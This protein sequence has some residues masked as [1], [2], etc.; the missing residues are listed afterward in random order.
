MGAGNGLRIGIPRRGPALFAYAVLAAL[1]LMALAVSASAVRAW[2]ATPQPDPASDSPH[3][4]KAP[5]DPQTVRAVG[6]PVPRIQCQAGYTARILAEGLSSPDG[7]A[8]SPARVLYVAE[9]TAGRVSRVES[10]GSVAPILGGLRNPEGIAFDDTG[11]LYVVEDVNAGRVVKMTAAGVTTTLAAGR[12]AP[13]GAVWSSDGLLY[14]T[15]SNVQ[16]ASSPFAFRT[17]VT[18]VSPGAG[19]TRI[20]TNTLPWSYAGIAIGPAG[21]LYV[22]NEASG[23][24]TDDSIFS[25]EPV[26]GKRELFASGLVAPE[27]S[28]FSTGGGFPLYVAEEN[29]GNAGGRLSRVEADGSHAPF[30]TGFSSIEDVVV[31]DAGRLFVSEDGTGSIIR[32]ELDP[33]DRA[34]A[35]AI[36]LFVGDGMGEAH[37]TAGRWSAAG[38]TGVLAMD[39]MPFGGW[40]RTASA[41]NSVTDSAAGATAIATGIKTD[42]GVI[43]QDPEGNPLTTILERAKAAGMAVGL[44]TTTQMAHATPAAFAAHVAQRSMMDEIARQMLAA[45]VDVLLGGGE[46]VFLPDTVVGCYPGLGA[47]TDGRNLID[48]AE[49]DGYTYVC[50]APTLAGVDPGPTTRLLG[51]FADEGLS[52]PFSPSLVEMTQKAID[53]LSNDPDGFFLMVEGGQIDWAAHSNDAANVISDT[54]GLDGA[55]AVAQA[56]ASTAGDVLIIVTADHETG[57]MRADLASSGA[58]DEDGPFFMPGGTPFYVNWT[59]GGHTA[60][61]VPIT[62]QGPWSDLLIGVFE[63]T[64]THDVMRLALGGQRVFM[65]IVVRVGSSPALAPGPQ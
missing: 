47:R 40:S 61:H 35:R 44:V 46:N 54:V 33:P 12:D 48:E 26:T 11:N 22:T 58:P 64:H 57:G 7:L 16:F 38:Q 55:V 42:N 43:G 4:P 28:S 29:V 65:P 14:I 10:Y 49:A 60:A 41:D 3:G 45:E 1:L 9:E 23:T 50:D 31:D 20:L 52:R 63:N 32:I 25:V 19:A 24:G 56:F 18:A 8:F 53:I 15:E 34:R 2:E 37:R 13:E 59:T 62:A 21:S 5:R 27:G 30:C 17:H 6:D 39:A 51:L 36:I